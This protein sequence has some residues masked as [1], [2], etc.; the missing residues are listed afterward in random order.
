MTIDTDDLLNSII[1]SFGKMT[2]IKPEDIPNIDLYMDQVTSF[3]D[4]RLRPTARVKVS[5]DRLMTKTMINNYAKNDV[6]PPPVKKKYSKEHILILIIVYYYKSILQINDIQDLITPI[7]DRFF[8]KNSDFGIEDIYNEIFNSKSEQLK[9]VT[10][11]VLEKYQES[12]KSF[13]D[14]PVDSKEYL[15]LFDFLCTLSCDI[16]VK[17]LLVEKIVDSLR[18]NRA[19]ETNKYDI[20]VNKKQIKDAYKTDNESK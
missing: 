18:E 8:G 15:Q 7:T 3:L 10:E 11:D 4:E 17:K 9:A 6:I 19:K 1:T 13:D 12:L 5:E 2:Y 20:S 14:A 16:F